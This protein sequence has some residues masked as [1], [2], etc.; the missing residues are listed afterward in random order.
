MGNAGG[1]TCGGDQLFRTDETFF[2]LDALRDIE[3]QADDRDAGLHRVGP[4]NQSASILNP[5]DASIRIHEAELDVGFAL[6]FRICAIS[7]L[8]RG[9]IG[10]I[11][12]LQQSSKRDFALWFT[13]T[14]DLSG[15]L[16]ER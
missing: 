9:S 15:L 6:D 1:K 12:A 8:D 5:A 16:G 14:K 11:D 3:A 4:R 10:W 2:G 13:E 7:G